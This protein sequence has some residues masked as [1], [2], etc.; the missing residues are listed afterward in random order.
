MHRLRLSI[1][2]NAIKDHTFRGLIYCHYSHYQQIGIKQQFRTT[3]TIEITKPAVEMQFSNSFASYTFDSTKEDIQTTFENL[4][5]EIA[6]FHQDRQKKDLQVG[7]VKIDLQELLKAPI[8]KTASSYVRVQDAFYPI[9][10]MEEQKGRIGLLRCLLYLEDLG[11]IDQLQQQE[12]KATDE[13]FQDPG[14]PIIKLSGSDDPEKQKL[15]LELNSLESKVIWELETWKKSEEAKFKVQLK[16]KEYEMTQKLHQDFKLKDQ[17][18]DKQLKQAQATLQL[19]ESK[20]K[21]KVTDLQKREQRIVQVEEELKQKLGETAKIVKQKDEEMGQLIKRQKDEKL[22]YE[23]DKTVLNLKLGDSQ[24]LCSKLEEEVKQLRKE[25][26]KSPVALVKTSLQEKSQEITELKKEIERV[27][28]VKDQYKQYYEKI[29]DELVR[30][31]RINEELQQ[32]QQY[33]AKQEIDKLRQDLQE[34]RELKKSQVV[35]QKEPEPVLPQNPFKQALIQSTKSKQKPINVRVPDTSN[36]SDLQRLLQEREY[37]LE[38][39]E[40]S[41]S[42]PLIQELT[43]QIQELSD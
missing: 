5:F 10:D 37:L 38:S 28:Q 3:P 19:I 31:K 9:D 17:E 23:K 24:G 18:R 11:P 36:L 14:L 22:Q 40:Y 25:M 15:V 6:I 26:D 29:R 35:V 1:D 20:V 30:Q 43:R 39:G 27:T 33:S 16:Q 34:L 7:V 2:I 12:Q 8:R 21:Q 13:I 42:D 32:N 4:N 41:E